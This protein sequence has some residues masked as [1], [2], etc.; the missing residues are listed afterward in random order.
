MRYRPCVLG[1]AVIMLALLVPA[2]ASA[3]TMDVPAWSQTDHRWSGLSLG[4]TSLTMSG[5]GCAVTASA[6]VASYYSSGKDPGQLCQALNANGGLAGGELQWGKIP[7]AAGGTINGPW[8]ISLNANNVSLITSQLDLGF[9]VLVWF[10]VP[11]N[12]HWVV[13]TGRDGDTYY[14]NDPNGGAKNADFGAKYGGPNAIQGFVIF[15]GKDVSRFARHIVQQKG[16][17]KKQKTSWY[18]SAD[19][20]RLWI[21]DAATFNALR[22]AG[23]PKPDV[24]A[25]EDLDALSDQKDHWAAAGSAMTKQRTL[26][27]EMSLRSANGKYTFTLRSDGNLALTG[28]GDAALWDAKVSGIDFLVFQKDGNLAGY[29]DGVKDAVWSTQTAGKDARRF[30]VRNDGVAAVLDVDG[31]WLWA[32]SSTPRPGEIFPITTAAGDQAWP[33]VSGSTVVWADYRNGFGSDDVDAPP[34]DVVAHDLATGTD[35]TIRAAAAAF[36]F[37]RVSGRTVVWADSRHGIYNYD[38]YGYDLAT[39][40]EFPICLA[41]GQQGLPRVSGSIVVWADD[42]NSGTTGADIYGYDLSTKREFPICTAPG[43]QIHPVVSGSIVVWVDHRDDDGSTDIYGYDLS[44]KR[45]FPICTDPGDQ[46]EPDV[47]GSV[48][49]WEENVLNAGGVFGYDVTTHRRFVICRGTNADVYLSPAISSNTVVFMRA[50]ID[51][52]A[53]NIELLG[54]RLASETLFPVCSSPGA[55]RW[56]AI[57]GNTVVWN[58]VGFPGRVNVDVYGVLLE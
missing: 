55:L 18:V 5:S 3:S 52:S 17:N 9:P 53:D 51:D 34:A 31:K 8:A 47:S 32:T 35:T 12:T 10:Y 6:M 33:A 27:R 36:C 45:E 41:S 16:D 42:R 7:A 48:V 28:P 58:D 11:G 14:M 13:L 21:P 22:S 2:I 30:V 44:T 49:V 15:H 20:R 19:L 43:D 24:L 40:R 50:P 29:K 37:P 1:V 38:I 25:A 4:G 26:R 57:S 56:P 46:A 54:Y 39:K 23:A